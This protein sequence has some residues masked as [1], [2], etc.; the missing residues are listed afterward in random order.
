MM[1]ART[2]E[3]VQMHCLII[4]LLL[5]VCQ[6]GFAQGLRTVKSAGNQDSS[7][8]LSGDS[9]KQQ[10]SH[11]VQP[12][13]YT[14]LEMHGSILQRDER[15]E[16]VLDRH[17]IQERFYMSFDDLLQGTL[18]AFFLNQGYYGLDNN[19]SVLGGSVRDNA[20]LYDGRPM[21]DLVSGCYSPNMYPAEFMQ[22]AEILLG[23]EAVVLADAASGMAMNIQEPRYNTKNPYTRLWYAE[24]A[25]GYISSDGVFSQN[26]APNWNM[27]VGYRREAGDGRY[28]NQAVDSWNL[29]A[30]L[31]WNVSSLTNISMTELFTNRSIGT[32]GGVD[33][34][35]TASIDNELT[36]FV[37]NPLLNQRTIRHDLSL[38]LSS[39]FASDSSSSL[40][41][42][43]Y[44]SH[45]L[46][47]MGRDL[48]DLLSSADSSLGIDQRSVRTGL[49]AS[50]EQDL[51]N[52]LH[53][54]VGGEAELQSA[55]S[56]EYS[57]SFSH[58][59]LAGFGRARLSLG[60]HLDLSGGAR[61]QIDG[62]I[63]T[64]SLGA[65]LDVRLNDR[66]QFRADASQSA[67]APSDVEGFGLNQEHHSLL[68]SSL[69]YA[70]SSVKLE[71]MAFTRYVTNPI[72][73][74]PV[75]DASG[76]TI[77]TTRFTNAD[78]RLCA[79]INL[80]GSWQG[81]PWR[82]EMNMQ[83][84]T[85]QLNGA[86]DKSLPLLNAGVQL[87]YEHH[88]GSSVLW[89]GAATQA[90]TPFD[91]Q[92]YVPQTWAYIPALVS[93]SS[94]FGGL[95]VL[96]G[97]HIGDAVVKLN[98]RNILSNSYSTLS[99]FPTVV[100]NLSISLAWTFFD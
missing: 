97:L 40:H 31:R 63:A 30:L 42:R 84:N 78:S 60:Q 47:H 87:L 65:R 37:F 16:R 79:G 26:I 93:Q 46:W 100:R 99:T 90:H 11:I 25:N 5:V 45:V 57:A 4:L 28:I 6:T 9:L 55:D 82:A 56:T 58:G 8:S 21:N 32:N 43:A 80:I 85:T 95:D 88:V 96:A 29:R 66:W 13:L 72:V 49:S 3:Y 15:V 48:I 23:S 71:G 54:N 53:L 64:L 94:V 2:F 83:V 86:A 12:N 74:S 76:T 50:F 52:F 20:L 34:A 92:S 7:S 69:T 68:Y 67:R 36:A 73:A 33:T 18:P 38:N 17:D 75:W 81:G 19:F 77:I 39:L 59:H 14:P 70:D 51:Q 22:R 98:Y 41:V 89:V 24:G 44:Y 10:A 27:T 62:S 61:V 91:G 35:G 1:R